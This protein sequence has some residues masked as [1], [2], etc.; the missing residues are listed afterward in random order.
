[1]MKWRAHIRIKVKRE[2]AAG[3]REPTMRDVSCIT[4]C[5]FTRRR[6][7]LGCVGST[8]LRFTGLGE[9]LTQNT[10]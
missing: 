2:R 5:P 8:C 3:L 10:S 4:Y 9:R 7:N 1:M 6:C